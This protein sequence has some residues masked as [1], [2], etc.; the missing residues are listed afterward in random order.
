[1]VL[2][3]STASRTFFGGLWGLLTTLLRTGFVITWDTTLALLN[4]ITPNKKAISASGLWGEYIPPKDTDSRSACPAL[5]ALCNHGVLPHDGRG[6]TFKQLGAA[7]NRYYNFSPSFCYFVGNYMANILHRDFGSDTLDLSDLSVHNGIEHDGSITRY[8]T[9]IQPDQ[10]KPDKRLV[11]E[12]F[13]L[14]KDGKS[15]TAA[16]L[17]SIITT[18]MAHSKRINGQFSLKGIHSFFAANN[19]ATL[20]LIFGGKIE[21]IRPFLLE[22]RIPD[23]WTNKFRARFGLT[24]PRFNAT[25]FRIMLG[26]DPAWQKTKIEI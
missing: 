8:D 19:A 26:V 9:A 11:E 5:N 6:I 18:R 24:M 7:V 17:S 16:N 25:T 15:I 22:E 14:S 1:M 3:I 21:D 4:L 23:G 10:S 13:A 12:L 20:L 2:W